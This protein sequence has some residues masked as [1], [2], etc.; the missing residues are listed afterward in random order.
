MSLN[1][2]AGRAVSVILGLV[3]TGSALGPPAQAGS[4]AGPAAA[5]GSDRTAVAAETA[6]IVVA[7]SIDGLKSGAVRKLGRERTPVLHRL[8]AE[9]ASTLNARSAREQTETLPNH[10]GMLTGRRITATHGGHGVTW[11]D[12]RTDPATVHEAAGQQVESVFS[13]VGITGSPALFASKSKFSLFERSWADHLDSVTILGHNGNLVDA[14]RADLGEQTRVLR[15][16]HLSKPDAVGHRYGFGSTK[17]F[18]AVAHTDTLLGRLVATIEEQGQADRTVLVVTA[19][20]GG[21]GFSHEDPRRLANYRV[22]FVV[23]GAGV[24]RGA[25]LY[26]LNPDYANPGRRRTGYATQPPPVRN[27]AL[28][29]LVTDLLGLGPV[30]GSAINA[31]QDLDVS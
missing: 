31:E 11:N 3:L 27:G 9:G 19:D 6:P 23:W 1:F 20:H 15:F 21:R 8:M 26:K 5:N 22:P 17:Y 18:N 13:T 12:A 25:D 10:T 30:P 29:N 28:A 7:V 16:V 14:V 2:R 24:A 4:D